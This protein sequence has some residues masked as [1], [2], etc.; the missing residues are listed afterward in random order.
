VNFQNQIVCLAFG[1]MIWKNKSKKHNKVAHTEVKTAE[2]MIRL[3]NPIQPD[4]YFQMTFYNV[5][6]RN[7]FSIK[8]YRV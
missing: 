5:D 8:L 7:K 3:I 4:F 2:Y 6:V 1:K